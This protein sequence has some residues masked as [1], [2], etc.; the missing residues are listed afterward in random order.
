VTAE[1]RARGIDMT[2]LPTFGGAEPDNTASVWS[3]DAT[4]LL[5]GEGDLDIV[6]REEWADALD[7][8]DRGL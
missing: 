5:V 6:S 7:R 1:H 4:H 8:Y 3:W 2:G